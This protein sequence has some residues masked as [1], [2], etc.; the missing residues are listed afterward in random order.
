[1]TSSKYE[2]QKLNMVLCF[3]S[4]LAAHPEAMVRSLADQ[5]KHPETDKEVFCFVVFCSGRKLK[6]RNIS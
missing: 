2:K 6:P 5:I 4:I 1:M 3:F